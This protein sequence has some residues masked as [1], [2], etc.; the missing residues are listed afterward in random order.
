MLADP[1]PERAGGERKTAAAKLIA[2]EAALPQVDGLPGR[3]HAGPGR[4]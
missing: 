2:D 4:E 1:V 3:A